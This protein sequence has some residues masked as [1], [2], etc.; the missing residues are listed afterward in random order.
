MDDD[1]RS[2]GTCVKREAE[3][4]SRNRSTFACVCR[5][6]AGTLGVTGPSTD[7]RTASAFRRSGTMQRM[8]RASRICR[9]DIEMARDGTSSMVSNQPFAHLLSPARFIERHDEVGL[10]CVEV[11]RRIVEG[12]MPVLADA[13]EGHIDRRRS[14]LMADRLADDFRILLAVEQVRGRDSGRTNQPLVEILAKAAP[15]AW[16][17]C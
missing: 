14:D 9:T 2:A 4:R 11:C 1:G 15:D 17:E 13:D 7:A 10:A 8:W 12:E 16:A 5:I 3:A 6:D